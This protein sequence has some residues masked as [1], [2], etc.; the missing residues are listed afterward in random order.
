MDYREY[1]LD[2]YRNPRNYGSLNGAG[3]SGLEQEHPQP[4]Q[5][6]NRQTPPSASR[7]AADEPSAAREV[8]LMRIAYQPIT[9]GEPPR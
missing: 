7:D 5:N 6:E 9:H 3:R 8:T 2:H 4:E 1:I